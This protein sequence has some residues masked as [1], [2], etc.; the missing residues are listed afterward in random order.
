M[1]QPSQLLNASAKR[2]LLLQTLVVDEATGKRYTAQSLG[3]WL[4]V[5]G[6]SQAST[7]SRAWG[8][9]CQAVWPLPPLPHLLQSKLAKQRHTGTG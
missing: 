4:R 9:L 8:C 1:S 5:A 3:A 2:A 7:S 6:A